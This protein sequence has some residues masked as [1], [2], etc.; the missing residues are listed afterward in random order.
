MLCTVIHAHAHEIA[1]VLLLLT[2][3]CSSELKTKRFGGSEA[4]GADVDDG[5]AAQKQIIP[6]TNLSSPQGSPVAQQLTPGSQQNPANIIADN[7]SASRISAQIDSDAAGQPFTISGSPLEDLNQS[8]IY[9]FAAVNGGVVQIECGEHQI[10]KLEPVVTYR[11]S[12]WLINTPT[13]P[14]MN[15]TS[16]VIDPS[17]YQ[18]KITLTSC[19]GAKLEGAQATKYP[20][21]PTTVRPAT[22]IYIQRDRAKDCFN[23]QSTLTFSFAHKVTNQKVSYAAAM[24][25]YVIP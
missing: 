12:C 3:G 4:N 20:I 18:W 6:K 22:Q 24:T 5:S 7:S 16:Y 13:S 23:D 25:E 1:F 9:S 15:S 8:A 10:Y 2:P 17:S 19:A 21:D 14:D 11:I